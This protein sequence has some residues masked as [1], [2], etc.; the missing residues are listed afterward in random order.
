MRKQLLNK[1]FALLMAAAAV[2]SIYLVVT[3]YDTRAA[4]DELY[5]DYMRLNDD[6]AQ[7]KTS[8]DALLDKTWHMHQQMMEEGTE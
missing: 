7:I 6:Y 8:Y 5:Q 1:L 3:I 2:A 4:Y